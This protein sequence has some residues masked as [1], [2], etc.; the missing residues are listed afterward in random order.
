MEPKNTMSNSLP[1]AEQLQRDIKEFDAAMTIVLDGP[2]KDRVAG[3]LRELLALR[4][5]AGAVANAIHA[6]SV[7]F[8]RGS[9]MEAELRA[10]LHLKDGEMMKIPR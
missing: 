5:S 4:L 1:D 2:D 6:G 10:A 3:Y 8:I 9:L 7:S